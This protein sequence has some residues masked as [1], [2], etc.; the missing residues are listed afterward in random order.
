MVVERPADPIFRKPG[1]K[2]GDKTQQVKTPVWGIVTEPITG[3]IQGEWT[4]YVPSS[5]VKFLEQTGAK[6]VPI[7]YNIHKTELL[8]I[9]DQ[10]SGIYFHGDSVEAPKS[11]KFQSTFGQ[12]LAYA[13]QHNH[14]LYDYFPVIMLGSTLQ[15]FLSN[16]LGHDVLPLS[17]MPL[18][19]FNKNVQL[20]A[21]QDPARSFI[22]DE[23]TRETVDEVMH[24]GRFFNR[25][26]LG[27]TV[28]Q[29]ERE[30]Q[31][32]KRYQVVATIKGDQKKLNADSEI[33][34]IDDNEYIAIMESFDMPLY[35]ILYDVSYTQFVYSERFFVWN[36]AQLID[37]SI[38]SRSHAQ[39]IA[40]QLRDEAAHCTHRFADYETL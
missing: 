38:A 22:L 40:N 28:R 23:L 21:T 19:H 9:L 8:A 3:K 36:G 12:I 33:K 32:N 30:A 17:Q 18:S 25:Q 5:H 7:S 39:Y 37:H 27:M 11:R 1:F 29:L 6:V 14:D 26:R 34:V 4:E 20:R 16:R 2:R 24:Q 10:I 15:T 31:L 35:F 13:F